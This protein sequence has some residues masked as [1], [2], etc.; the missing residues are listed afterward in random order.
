M[1]RLD[2][3]LSRLAQ[4]LDPRALVYCETGRSGGA[5]EAV[6]DTTVETWRLEI[7]GEPPLGLGDS[8][9]AAQQAVKS[10]LRARRAEAN[11]QTS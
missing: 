9:T 10:L 3:Y 5:G 7:P 6:Y 4:Q 11:A 8:F 2:G 1:T